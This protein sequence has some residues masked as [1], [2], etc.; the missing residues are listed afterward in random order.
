MRDV[1][2]TVINYQDWNSSV[3]KYVFNRRQSGRLIRLAIDP[4]VLQ[5][6]AAEGS[7]RHHFSTPEEAAGDFTAAVKTTIAERGW[8]IGLCDEDVRVPPGLAKLA[9]QVLAVFHIADD[10]LTGNG[11]WAALTALLGRR[12]ERRGVMPRD[13]YPERHQDNWNTLVRWAN[14]MRQGRLGRLPEVSQLEGGHRH[15]RFPMNHGLLRQGDIQKLPRFFGRVGFAPGEEVDAEEILPLLRLYGDDPLVFPGPHARRVLQ[16]ERIALAAAQVANAL[17]LWDGHR[18]SMSVKRGT[19]YRLWLTADG[20]EAPKLNGGLQSV[21]PKGTEVEVP[22][23]TLAGLFLADGLA[24]Y[25]LSVPYRPIDRTLVLTVQSQIDGRY[26]E[27]RYGRPGDRVIIASPSS[28][29]LHWD[30]LLSKAATSGRVDRIA[31]LPVGWS[32]Y[33]IKLREDLAEGDVPQALVKRI[34]FCRTRLKVEGG[35]R[36]RGMWMTGAGP[37]LATVGDAED[38]IIVNGTEFATES[39]R[40]TPAGC[41]LLNLAGIHE[42]WLPGR[43]TEHVRFRVGQP[44]PTRHDGL[45][46]DVGWKWS[47]TGWPSRRTPLSEGD[48]GIIA[49]LH[50]FG[51]WPLGESTR[52][53]VHTLALALITQL[54][55]GIAWPFGSQDDLQKAMTHP[56][57][58]VRTLA[59]AAS[60]RH[61]R[62]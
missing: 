14:T 37:S 31:D 21:S 22:K 46:D 28:R 49:G 9:L 59:R 26:R 32:A 55:C 41:P 36:V 47:P 3:G 43:Y 24:A 56:N 34:R 12:V 60:R 45:P 19:V 23:I 5:R 6:A 27:T 51:D 20:Q 44:R 8:F 33:R 18:V 10:D 17:K 29:N 38:T 54:R 1:P 58:L 15:V 25:G 62:S 35:L 7:R 16:D 52:A 4:I 2:Q 11:Y 57:L 40:L 50:I 48:G 61:F 13:L 39:G 42:A 30:L 53:P